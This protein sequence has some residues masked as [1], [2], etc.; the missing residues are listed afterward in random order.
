MRAAGRR[1]NRQASLAMGFLRIIFRA[2]VDRYRLVR[3]T[4][5]APSRNGPNRAP[6]FTVM[7]ILTI[8]TTPILLLLRS[9]FA[10]AMELQIIHQ[11]C[12]AFATSPYPSLP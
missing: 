2:M 10:E 7:Y 1:A 5:Q 4:R 8:D 11:A 12:F 9:G 6:V 3:D